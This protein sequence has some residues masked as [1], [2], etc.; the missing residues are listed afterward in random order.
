MSLELKGLLAHQKTLLTAFQDIGSWLCSLKE[1]AGA[2]VGAMAIQV[3][4]TESKSM[5]DEPQTVGAAQQTCQVA[6]NIRNVAISQA[7]KQLID[8]VSTISP[9]IT[10]LADDDVLDNID[11]ILTGSSPAQRRSEPHQLT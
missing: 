5:V 1:T 7:N 11:E 6:T 2:H 9:L 10:N 8:K 4:L 3:W